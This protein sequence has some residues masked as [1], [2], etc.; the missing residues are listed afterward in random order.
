MTHLLTNIVI[1]RGAPTLKKFPYLAAVRHLVL[2]VLPGHVEDESA[3]GPQVHVADLA[4]RLHILD[5]I[6]LLL[7]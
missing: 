7:F 5:K 6:K 1:H 2:D 4:G 3:G